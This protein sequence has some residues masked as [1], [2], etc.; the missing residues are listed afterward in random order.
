MKEKN[1]VVEKAIEAAREIGDKKVA[2]GFKFSGEGIESTNPILPAVVDADGRPY[3]QKEVDR[4]V[5]AFIE[6][7]SL[8]MLTHSLG[9]AMGTDI[10]T[11]FTLTLAACEAHLKALGYT[12]K[13]T[14]G[15][16]TVTVS[17]PG[18]EYTITDTN[19][20]LATLRALHFLALRH[21][22]DS[23]E[24]IKRRLFNELTQ[25]GVD[26]TAPVAENKSIH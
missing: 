2:E 18:G 19:R 22:P 12:V 1:P 16:F 17:V 8:G 24:F 4:Q 26:I 3:S 23:T 11:G 5:D 20:Q 10:P 25:A 21:D 7:Q 13:R 9:L 14:G 6:R 15:D